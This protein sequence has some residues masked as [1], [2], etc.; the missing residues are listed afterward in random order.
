MRILIH[1]INFHPEPTGIGKYSGEMAAELVAMGHEVRVVAAPPYYPDWRIGDGW[2]NGYSRHEWKGVDVWR[3]PLWVPAQPSGLKRI[4]HLTSFSVAALPVLARQLL[5]RPDMV[6]VVAPALTSAPGGWLTARLSGARC[7]LHVQDFEV[8]AAFELGLISANGIVRKLVTGIE[9]W[10]LRRFD[11]VS[12]ISWRMLDRTRSKGVER[13]RLVFLPNWVN[14]QAARPFTGPSRYRQELGIAEDAIVAL[15]S[16]TLG[17]KQGLELLPKVAQRIRSHPKLVMV[18]CGDGVMKPHL[19]QA[20]A[21]MDNVRMLPLQPA[22]RLAELLHTADIHM[23]PQNPGA[24]DLV[25]PSKLSGML[26]SGRPVVTTTEPGTEL[27]HVVSECGRVVPPGDDRAF[28]DALIELADSP[29]LR[30]QLGLR[31]NQYAQKHLIRSVVLGRLDRCLQAC[32]T[33]TTAG[34]EL[35][36]ESTQTPK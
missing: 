8:D 28:A 22:E 24:A 21:G 2:R 23:L 34:V 19:E 16:G 11:R 14:D 10:L 9:Q 32:A 35:P 20:C 6:M 17:G 7:W 12:T 15:F 5:W 31:A 27:A 3:V 25:M 36:R 18:I 1:G 26:G 13:E 29:A 4:I 30:Q 33:H